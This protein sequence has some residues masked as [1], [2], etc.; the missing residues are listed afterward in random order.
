MGIITVENIRIFAHHGCLKEETTIGSDYRVDLE[1]EADLQ[2]SAL[3]DK[4]ND[5]VDYVFLNRIIKEEMNKPSQLLET[6]AKRI[7]TRIFNE[8]KLVNKATVWVSKLNPPIG[9]DVERVTIKMSEIRK[10]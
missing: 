1:I 2:T 10:K 7:L 6:V 9:G 4:L 8:D 3:S 5:T